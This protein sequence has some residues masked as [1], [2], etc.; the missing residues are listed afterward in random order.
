MAGIAGFA[1]LGCAL[2]VT[3]ALAPAD[4]SGPLALVAPDVGTEDART[5]GELD[6][7]SDCVRIIHPD[8][9]EA[10]LIWLQGSV[11]WQA[12][13]MSIRTTD[14]DGKQ[15]VLRDGDAI[16]AGGAGGSRDTLESAG[17]WIERPAGP[18]VAAE[19]FR[20]IEVR[21]EQGG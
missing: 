19:W 16:S 15:L 11:Q 13:D 3:E 10:L 20:V 14:P 9:S 4:Q 18:C 8:G 5:S 1:L 6:I 21:Q 17:R 7:T 12:S 2:I